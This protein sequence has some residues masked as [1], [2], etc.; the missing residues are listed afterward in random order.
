[1]RSLT[2]PW[3]VHLVK[4]SDQARSGD[5]QR[6]LV[7]VLALN[8][9]VAVAK[10]VVGI[11]SGTLSM[12]A[13]GFHSTMDASSNVVGIVAT[14]LAAPPADE[15]PPYGHRRFETMATL[16]IGGGLLL[17]AWEILKAALERTSNGV[18]AT[19]QPLTFAVMF[20]TVIV[21]LILVI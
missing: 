21:N 12:V 14:V 2:E 9:L 3:K 16:T 6:V 10:I 19:A 17:A 7:K 11:S 20:A 15:S 8:F 13:D 5:I 18:T 4:Q 1:M